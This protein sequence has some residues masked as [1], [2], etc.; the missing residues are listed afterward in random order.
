MIR[1]GVFIGVDKTGNLQ[2]LNDAAAGAARM[3]AWALDQGL[4]P[5]NATLIT[6]AGGKRVTPDAIYDAVKALLDGPGVDQLILY[7]AGHGVNINRQEQW[8]LTDAPVRANAAVNVA[9]SVYLA[10]R[11]GIGHVVVISDACRVAAEGIQAQNVQGGDVFPNEDTGFKAKPVDQFFAC[12]LGRTAAEIRDPEVAATSFS[13]LFTNALLDA[14]KGLRP[15]VLEPAA[16]PGDPASYVMPAALAR[17]LE[18]EIPVRV[19]ARNLQHTV[20]QDP[21]AI[22]ALGG[23]WISRIEVPRT[24]GL[25]PTR[26][27]RRGPPK[28]PQDDIRGA[29]RSLVASAARG[30][31]G[32][33]H[34]RVAD[35]KT[36]PVAA[37]REL[38]A[39]VE[40]LAAPFLPD[41]FETGCGIKI[42]GN[43]I[44]DQ[45][46]VRGRADT[47]QP[48]ADAIRVAG[49]DGPAASV[50]LRFE[51]GVGTVV[52]VI[53]GFLTALTFEDEALVD[54]TFE[55]SAPTPR[56][57]EYLQRASEVRALHAVAAA[58]LQR[59]R[60]RLEDAEAAGLAEQVRSAQAIDPALAV[61]AAYALHD[62]Q[63]VEPIAQMAGDGRADLGVT[64]F[65]VALLGRLLVGQTIGADAGVVPFVPLLTQ[66]WPLLRAGRVK[67]H[68]AL[69]GL[70]RNTRDSLWSLY[71]SAGLDKLEA[72]LRSKDVR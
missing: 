36:V 9:G 57:V 10:Q 20:N 14:L 33:F 32:A 64:L 37:T 28:Q 46:L 55:P 59:G 72:A 1:A 11:C 50:L 25:A 4:D 67:L 26:G 22:L 58:A 21:E 31:P 8:L 68:P 49:L 70:E 63:L 27:P 45:V 62:L 19:K 66:A 15:D 17:Y 24:R 30:A 43:R 29:A 41:H 7:F 54:V 13:A 56:G 35:L 5:A 42:R 44:I 48:P 12:V 3:H 71:D 47:W 38:A 23:S 61:Y 39:S 2:R 69:D 18:A 6:D 51:G 34:T 65:D 40:R 60:F 52:P 53:A 16:S